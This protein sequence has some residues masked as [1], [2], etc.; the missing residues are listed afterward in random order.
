MQIQT[1]YNTLL[2]TQTSKKEEAQLSFDEAL[3]S[4]YMPE[5]AKENLRTFWSSFEAANGKSTTQSQEE[6][7]QEN[8]AVAQFLH[9]LRTK[10]AVKFLADFNQ[11]KIDKMV[12]EYKEKLLDQ[13]GDSPQTL[14]EIESLI[15]AYKKQLLE[16]LQNS[17]DADE[18]TTPIN[19]NAMVQLLLNA[20]EK[21]EKPLE[22]L[23]HSKS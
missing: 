13:M 17:L 12:E 14:K 1:S 21:Q 7:S 22:K 5:D 2:S 9:D 11:E 19:A 18:K 23:L 3:A 4:L 16:E 8:L 20:Q 15:A 6:N 10:G